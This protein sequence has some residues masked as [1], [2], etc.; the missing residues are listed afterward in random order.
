[1]LLFLVLSAFPNTL[2]F[3]EG[4]PN[5][6]GLT[7][8]VAR[9]GVSSLSKSIPALSVWEAH[10]GQCS[11]RRSM[12]VAVKR[13]R[14]LDIPQKV[15]D[16]GG[17]YYGITG[18]TLSKA[19]KPGAIKKRLS[20]S[21][22]MYEALE[23]LKT[24]RKEMEQMRSDMQKLRWKML[25]D[26]DLEGDTEEN[27]EKEKILKRKRAKEADSLSKEIEKW[28]KQVLLETEEDGWKNVEC[29]KMM[30]KTLNPDGLTTA[31]IKWMKDSRGDKADKNDETEYPCI[32][33]SSTIDA[34]MEDVCTYLSQESAL[35][36]YNDLVVEY[37]DVEEISPSAKI[38]ASWT[39]QILFIK[40]REFVTFCHHKWKK[41]GSEVIVSQAWTHHDFP[42]T[43]EESSGKA[44]RAYALRGANMI[45][46]CPDDA[47]K[48]VITM[49]SH[50]NPGGNVPAWACK[51]A[52]NAMAPVEP[53]KIF[54]KINKNVKQNLPQL[55]ERLEEA[56]MV[57]SPSGRS[58]RPAGIAQLGYACFW[59]K[60]GGTVEGA[61]KAL[62][63]RNGDR[64]AN[65]P[66]DQSSQEEATEEGG[67]D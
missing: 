40:R 28:A 25:M 55:R 26:G 17:F 41:D 15:I 35:P 58:P 36:D 23:E 1:V 12:E 19:S 7:Q 27:K 52:V 10:Q 22:S 2:L 11:S 66:Y 62:V 31:S 57:S 8:K 61:P 50:A 24:M 45:S 38:C 33:C 9:R 21:D 32:R 6:S 5:F 56:E 65:A 67:G 13:K 53:F 48:T 20:L 18:D 4:G 3:V 60:G 29:S 49:I 34:P 14:Q 39:P 16:G 46:R 42:E 30:R 44:C 51:T 47:D 54:Q 59:P 43:K 63:D 64:I 37:K